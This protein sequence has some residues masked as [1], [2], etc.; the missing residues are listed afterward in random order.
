MTESHSEKLAH[1]VQAALNLDERPDPAVSLRSL[2]LDS[3]AVLLLIENIES[4]FGV[5][6]DGDEIL[7]GHFDSVERL[8]SFLDGKLSTGA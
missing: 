1:L 7:P 2:G 3:M 4:E 6:V 5:R 8:A